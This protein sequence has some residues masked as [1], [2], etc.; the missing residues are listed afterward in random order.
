MPRQKTVQK[1][2]LIS[3]NCV[4]LGMARVRGHCFLLEC[5]SIRTIHHSATM[6]SFTAPATARS[7]HQRYTKL[8]N[9]VAGCLMRVFMCLT[10]T[11]NHNYLESL[12]KEI[13][14]FFLFIYFLA[15]VHR[16]IYV[17]THGILSIYL[18][19]PQL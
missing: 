7:K 11:A 6:I 16:M 14:L 8:I 19:N 3:H 9:G 15:L 17:N 10:L 13:L 18:S 12:G 4:P 2:Q 1:T 5:G